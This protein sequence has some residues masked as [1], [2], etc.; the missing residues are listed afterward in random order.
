MGGTGGVE[1]QETIIRI[2][3]VKKNLFSIIGKK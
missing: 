3:H 1:G 2:Q